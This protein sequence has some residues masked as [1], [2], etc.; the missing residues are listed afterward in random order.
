MCPVFRADLVLAMLGWSQCARLVGEVVVGAEE[1]ASVVDAAN[2]EARDLG[3]HTVDTPH[4]LLGL[5]RVDDQASVRLRVSVEF[6]RDQAT[7]TKTSQG[8]VPPRGQRLPM[9]PQAEW[10]LRES[11]DLRS[12]GVQL[13]RVGLASRIV[14]A[15]R[16][17]AAAAG[18]RVAEVAGGR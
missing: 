12:L 6:V 4:L 14:I 8:L 16:A 1:F 13:E 3:H 17:V 10:V 7:R 15:G 11:W 2:E 5:L 9:T 18:A